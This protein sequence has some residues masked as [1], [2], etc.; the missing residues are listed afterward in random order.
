MVEQHM[1]V[2]AKLCTILVLVEA[3][4][5]LCGHSHYS[6]TRSVFMCWQY[7]LDKI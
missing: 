4:P 7:F 5:R 3:K 6:L 1:Q 2:P